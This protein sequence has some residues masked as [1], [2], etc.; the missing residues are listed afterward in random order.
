MFKGSDG[1]SVHK[2][3]LSEQEG[4]NEMRQIKRNEREAHTFPA[5]SLEGERETLDIPFY[6]GE[7]EGNRKRGFVCKVFREQKTF[8]DLSEL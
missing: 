3:V 7:G 1:S 4:E 2:S 5:E 8:T 6:R